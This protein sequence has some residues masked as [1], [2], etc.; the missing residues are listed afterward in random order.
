M[1]DA[2]LRRHDAEVVQRILA[3]AQEEIAFLIAGEFKIG[4]VL[5]REP[6]VPKLS[7]CTE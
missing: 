5:E 6:G 3:P 7:T 2:R 4:V 1:D